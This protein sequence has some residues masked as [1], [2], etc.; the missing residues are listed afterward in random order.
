MEHSPEERKS[1]N[2]TDIEYQPNSRNYSGVI[3]LYIE[4]GS[5]VFT[6]NSKALQLTFADCEFKSLGEEWSQ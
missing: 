2:E 1:D 6:Q 4:S 5:F 3:K